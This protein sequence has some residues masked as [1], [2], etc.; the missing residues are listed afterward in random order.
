MINVLVDY[1][2][3]VRGHTVAGETCEI[4][5]IG[6][7]PVS[8]VASWQRDAYL[9]LIVT[10]GVDIKAVTR[11]SRFV[12]VDQ[13]RAL[14]V[15]DRS[16]VVERCDA[17]SRLQRDHRVPFAQVGPPKSTTCSTCAPSTTR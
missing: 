9:S 1:E 14:A 15:R 8:L 13:R 3:L 7:V 11:A 12:D 5:G 4:E 6:S 16:C 10:H 2:A 17:D